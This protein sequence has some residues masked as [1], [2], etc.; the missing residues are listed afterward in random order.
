MYKIISDEH[1]MVSDKVLK[2]IKTGIKDF[3]KES[4]ET[5][6]ENYLHIIKCIKKA[7]IVVMEISGH[8]VSMGFILSKAMEEN[9]PVIAM[10]TS[11]MDPV[12]VK[13]I[14]NSKLILA[15]YKKENLEQVILASINKAKC[16]V[17]MRFNFFVSPKILNYLDWVAQ[18]RMIPKSVFLRHLIE[19]EMKK[20]REFKG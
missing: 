14:V 1:K 7:D 4:I 20:D 9:K 17:D 18:K 6:K 10:Y 19:R 11:D 5:K 8:S 3:S 15:E 2:W 13:G 12:F 16:L